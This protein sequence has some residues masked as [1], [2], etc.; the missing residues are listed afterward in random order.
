MLSPIGLL[1]S[2][3]GSGSF[4]SVA[5]WRVSDLSIL[6]KRDQTIVLSRFS[7]NFCKF[8]KPGSIS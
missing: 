8:I 5:F 7:H 6:Q 3:T 1:N 4:C 2:L